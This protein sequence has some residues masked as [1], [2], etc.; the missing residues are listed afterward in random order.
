MDTAEKQK[1]SWCDKCKSWHVPGTCLPMIPCKVCGLCHFEGPCPQRF[2][3]HCKTFHAGSCKESIDYMKYRAKKHC[4]PDN[5]IK[6]LKSCVVKPPDKRK[7]PVKS[8]SKYRKKLK[9]YLPTEDELKEVDY[10]VD[11]NETTHKVVYECLYY[12]LT[13]DE[14]WFLIEKHRSLSIQPSIISLRILFKQLG[15][16]RGMLNEA[17][18]FI[19]ENHALL[20]ESICPNVEW[21][22]KDSHLLSE[23]TKLLKRFN[24]SIDALN[25]YIYSYEWDQNENEDG[26]YEEDEDY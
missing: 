8:S 16:D 9:E 7:S 3:E 6:T 17:I 1:S 21:F 2:C 25:M 15:K 24:N 12:G 4:V 20:Y 22:S 26:E 18:D 23:F 10:L 13:L 19:E 11:E 14:T 5:K